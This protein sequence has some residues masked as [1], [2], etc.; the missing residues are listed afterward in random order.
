[1]K[2]YIIL[3]YLIK[4]KW[5]EVLFITKQNICRCLTNHYFFSVINKRLI[6]IINNLFSI[7]IKNSLIMYVPEPWEQQHHETA[8]VQ[9]KKRF[10]LIFLYQTLLRPFYF[11]TSYY[12]L[13]CV[14]HIFT[15]VLYCAG[16][17]G[18]HQNWVLSMVLHKYLSDL[19]AKNKQTYILNFW[20]WDLVHSEVCHFFKST[21]SQYFF[22]K[23]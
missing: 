16:N 19:N 12:T 15:Q 14:L 23:I 1:M 2:Y 5:H 17:Q 3:Q 18:N 13:C 8:N 10:G 9:L 6:I 20:I 4:C 11:K 21:S 22:T 7:K